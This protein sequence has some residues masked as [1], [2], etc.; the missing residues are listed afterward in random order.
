MKRLLRLLKSEKAIILISYVFVGIIISYSFYDVTV[1]K[2]DVLSYSK[3]EVEGIDVELVNINTADAETLC[4]L[5]SVGEST[6]NKIIEYRNEHGGFKSIEEISEIS[7]I[8][9]QDYIRL[10]PLITV[11]D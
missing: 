2:T 10:L 4:T 9:Y 11:G 5:P 7:G 8:G 1:D 3:A 6:A